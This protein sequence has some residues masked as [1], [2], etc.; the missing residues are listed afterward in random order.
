MLLDVA[1]GTVTGYSSL[2]G[3]P[4]ERLATGGVRV[5]IRSITPA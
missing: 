3:R 5:M 2:V 1:G 4:G